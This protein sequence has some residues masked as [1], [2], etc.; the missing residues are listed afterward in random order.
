MS[1]TT[2]YERMTAR[3]SPGARVSMASSLE[4]PPGPLAPARSDVFAVVL[5]LAATVAV[6]V[7]VDVVV[8]L[9]VGPVS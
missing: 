6:V 2:V 4:Q 8:M 1:V 7:L 9:T 3:E 5:A